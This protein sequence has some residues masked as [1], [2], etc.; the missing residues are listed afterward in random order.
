MMHVSMAARAPASSS[1]RPP[2]E[3]LSLVVMAVMMVHLLV[4]LVCWTL[5]P[6]L[7]V[8]SLKPVWRHVPLSWKND[9]RTWFDPGEFT[10]HPDV[11]VP[12]PAS[13]PTPAIPST[14]PPASPPP[15]PMSVPPAAA[16][17][18]AGVGS[19]PVPA[20]TASVTPS[21]ES[22]TVTT[23]PMALTLP[24][25]ASAPEAGIAPAMAGT[26][27][28]LPQDASLLADTSALKSPAATTTAAPKITNKTITLS[29]MSDQEDEGVAKRIVPATETKMRLEEKG[30]EPTGG[31]NMDPVL[32]ALEVAL[33]KE[34]NAPA[35]QDVPAAQR[36]S[37]LKVT[38]G[39]DGQTLEVI[40]SKPSGSAVLDQS[41][42]NAGMRVKKISESLPSSFPKDRYTVEVTFHIE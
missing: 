36:A 41:V 3:P 10:L 32:K 4:G 12:A 29:P 23:P 14:P 22:S 9:G 6:M 20:P 2:L 8:A 16:A 25:E 13:A 5:L 19:A 11:K 31:A 30:K 15:A 33:K 24:A 1:R 37:T 7:P 35:L 18:P 26:H 17:P 40:M 28:P 38:L 42:I 34:W 39:R 21:A 27:A